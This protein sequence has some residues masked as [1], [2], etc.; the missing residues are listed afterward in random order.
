M[1]LRRDPEDIFKF[2]SEC[3]NSVTKA[4]L[5]IIAKHKDDPFTQVNILYMY[6]LRVCVCVCL[7]VCLCV[8]IT[9]AKAW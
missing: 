6:V 5:P 2:S 9:S 8:C 3:A 7:F 1:M 4:Y